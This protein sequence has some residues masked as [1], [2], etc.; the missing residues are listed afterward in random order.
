MINTIMTRTDAFLYAIKKHLE[1]NRA[2]LDLSDFNKIELAISL[3]REGNAHVVMLAQVDGM[4][5]GCL[6]G[7]SRVDRFSFHST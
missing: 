1:K 4:V 3:N 6:D 5:M 7:N 2:A